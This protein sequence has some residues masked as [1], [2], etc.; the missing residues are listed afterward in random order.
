MHVCYCKIKHLLSYEYYTL[1]YLR[2]V[3]MLE[4]LSI[5][6]AMSQVSLFIKVYCVAMLEVIEPDILNASIAL[7]TVNVFTLFMASCFVIKTLMVCLN[8]LF[9]LNSHFFYV[10]KSR[11]TRL[12]IYV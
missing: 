6:I 1:H 12:L 5:F 9:Y 7:V 8:I 10:Q 11:I 2:S 3:R 4:S